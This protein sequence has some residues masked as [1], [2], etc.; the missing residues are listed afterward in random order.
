MKTL[1][2]LPLPILLL[3]LNS[4]RILTLH[5]P[6]PSPF[7][8][9]EPKA[10]DPKDKGKGLAKGIAED[11]DD[12]G[13]PPLTIAEQ[14]L[15]AESGL[16]NCRLK[17]LALCNPMVYPFSSAHSSFLPFFFPQCKACLKQNSICTQNV[18]TPHINRCTV[19]TASKTASSLVPPKV[20]SGRFKQHPAG[21]DA[22]DS[23]V[24]EVPAPALKAPKFQLQH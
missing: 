14:V 15:A 24:E 22:V 12:D 23:D 18:D 11:G 21:S 6:A 7:E 13:E 10:A 4:Q 2:N 8:P 9:S 19:C 1:Q 16:G 17:G 3:N 5:L 20:P